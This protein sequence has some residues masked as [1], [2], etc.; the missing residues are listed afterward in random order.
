MEIVLWQWNRLPEWSIENL[1]WKHFLGLH[2]QIAVG[3][4]KV[5]DASFAIHEH[6]C[7]CFVARYSVLSANVDTFGNWVKVLFLKYLI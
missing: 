2:K 6:L 7:W 4:D 5:N 1:L 3:V